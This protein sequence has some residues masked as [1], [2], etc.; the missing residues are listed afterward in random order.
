MSNVRLRAVISEE[1]TEKETPFTQVYDKDYYFIRSDGCV[2]VEN[3]S[4]SFCDDEHHSQTEITI[5]TLRNARKAERDGSSS[6]R[7]KKLIIVMK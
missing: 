4:N 1:K 2:E 7:N 3:D 5:P 6:Q